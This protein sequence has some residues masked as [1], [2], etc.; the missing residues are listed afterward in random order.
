MSESEYTCSTHLVHLFTIT[1]RDAKGISYSTVHQYKKVSKH[2]GF[3]VH[4]GQ[5]V[6]VLKP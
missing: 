2:I 6:M 4:S 3:L 5:G 1:S